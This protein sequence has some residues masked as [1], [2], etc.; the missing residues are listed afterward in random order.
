MQKTQETQ[1]Q[2]L[3]REDPLEKE[4]ATYSSIFAGKSHGQRS[5][6]GSSPQGRKDSD[7]TKA[8]E[9]ASTKRFLNLETKRQLSMTMPIHGLSISYAPTLAQ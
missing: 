5:L 8:T 1:I 3:A 6:V 2:T 4:M 7:I 9:H